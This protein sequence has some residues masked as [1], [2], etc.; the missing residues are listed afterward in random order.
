MMHK[1]LLHLAI[2]LP[3]LFLAAETGT[4]EPKDLAAQLQEEGAASFVKS[5]ND[6]IACIESKHTQIR[7]AS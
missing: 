1:R 5:W 2:A 7:K 4:V 6:L 3:V